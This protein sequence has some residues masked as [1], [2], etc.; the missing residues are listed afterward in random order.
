MMD[1]ESG[2]PLLAGAAWACCWVAARS[3]RL[4]TVG[5]DL[6]TACRLSF[7]DESALGVCIHDDALYKCDFTRDL[8]HFG[9]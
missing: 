5:S 4:H 9:S 7:S 2:D 8:E 6:K 3:L 1:Y